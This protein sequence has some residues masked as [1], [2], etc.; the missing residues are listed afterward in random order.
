MHKDFFRKCLKNYSAKRPA[1]VTE[2]PA[3]P[4]QWEGLLPLHSASMLLSLMMGSGRKMLAT[5]RGGFLSCLNM[6][7]YC[8]RFTPI[9]IAT[10]VAVATN[11][12]VV[13]RQLLEN[14]HFFGRIAY[15]A[16]KQPV[17]THFL[18]FCGPFFVCPVVGHDHKPCVT[19]EPLWVSLERLV[20]TAIRLIATVTVATCIYLF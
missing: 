8:S 17:A 7:T 14:L 16:Q 11:F 9:T 12:F 6:T 19:A 2:Y 4:Y 15:M 3:Q 13:L 5:G 1:L 18:T 10:F 20:Y